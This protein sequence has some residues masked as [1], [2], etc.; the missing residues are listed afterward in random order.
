M[1]PNLSDPKGQ[2]KE[3]EVIQGHPDPFPVSSVVTEDQCLPHI[4]KVSTP[5][6]SMMLFVRRTLE[7]GT[8]PTP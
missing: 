3:S 7:R 8:D 1:N 5:A 6:L 2:E 4:K